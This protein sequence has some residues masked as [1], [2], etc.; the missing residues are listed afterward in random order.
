MTDALTVLPGLGCTAPEAIERFIAAAKMLRNV[1]EQGGPN[2]GQMVEIM[3]A[4]VGLKRG[5][6]WCAAY[7]SYTGHQSFLDEATP[8]KTAWPLPMTGGC[9]LLGEAGIKHNALHT[10][11]QRGDLFLLYFPSLG[12]FAH[13]GIVLEVLDDHGLCRTLEG[14]TN[15]GDG[16][17]EGYK[18]SLR[19]RRLHIDA[20][21]RCLRWVECVPT[22]PV[23]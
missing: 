10:T 21:D 7:V 17:R 16:S 14:N 20:G 4:L 22:S 13:V 19:T 18:V 8:T 1:T 3:L 11:P 12:R 5:Q 6:P 23:G 9:A 15:D 2:A